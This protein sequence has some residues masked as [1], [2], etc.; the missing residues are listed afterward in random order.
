MKYTTLK[1]LAVF[2]LFLMLSAASVHAQSANRIAANIPFNFTA[3]DAKLKAGEYT[4]QRDNMQMLVVTS[5]D[6]K[7]RAFVL[8][9]ET[10]R[11]MRNDMREK[12]VFHRH[13]DQYFLSEVWT[14][15]ETEGN[16]LYASDAERRLTKE[17][18]RTK[19]DPE[20]NRDC[21][22]KEMNREATRTE[23]AARRSKNFGPFVRF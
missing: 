3:G 17:L 9:P 6:G 2:G 10:V 22:A 20:K 1:T 4:I 14:S 7:T 15:R 18:A 19:A 5:A 16:G 23:T 11:R 13:G 12:L 8:A 21:S